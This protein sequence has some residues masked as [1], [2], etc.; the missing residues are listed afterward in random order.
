M[1]QKYTLV[2]LGITFLQFGLYVYNKTFAFKDLKLKIFLKF[3]FP[4]TPLYIYGSS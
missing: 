3:W 1:Y 4:V 2:S